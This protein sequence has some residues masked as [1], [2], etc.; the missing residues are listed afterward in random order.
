MVIAELFIE[1]R[2]FHCVNIL[3]SKNSV[4]VY[5]FYIQ[6]SHAPEPARLKNS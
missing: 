5:F 3:V 6:S 4:S 1:H 2:R